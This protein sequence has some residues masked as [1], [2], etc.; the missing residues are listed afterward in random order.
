MGSS[1]LASKSLALPTV[2]APLPVSLVAHFSCC[3]YLP[4]TAFRALLLPHFAQLAQLAR[5]NSPPLLKG[6]EVNAIQVENVKRRVT[7]P[8]WILAKTTLLLNPLNFVKWIKN[9]LWKA[10]LYLRF[11]MNKFTNYSDCLSSWV[12]MFRRTQLVWWSLFLIPSLPSLS[13]ERGRS[14]LLI[15][16][17]YL[18]G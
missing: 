17:H 5:P 4:L 16:S 1:Q 14:S 3:P 7:Q 6:R 12:S 13:F 11:C 8:L 10:N 18:P 9:Q 2:I 15:I